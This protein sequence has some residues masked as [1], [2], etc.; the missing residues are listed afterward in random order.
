MTQ[1][2]DNI[3]RL[4]TIPSVYTAIQNALGAVSARK[5]FISEMLRPAAGAR[6]L[7]CGCGPGSMLPFLPQVDY[8][9]IDLNPKHVAFAREKY[10]DRA[11]FFVGDVSDKLFGRTETFDLVLVFGIL[12]H[13][14]DHAAHKLFA[15]A[16]NL[17]VSGGRIVTFDP[18]WFHNQNYMARILKSLDSGLNIRTAEGYLAL[19]EGLPL[20]S[21]TKIYR[22]LLRVPY[23]HFCMSLTRI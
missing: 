16:A 10:G 12:H 4:M 23:D 2:I 8:T 6:L 14:D 19:T 18:V 20:R 11:Q 3:Y 22:D 13:L 17:V 5:R 9:G 1:R 21:E 15:G 7:D